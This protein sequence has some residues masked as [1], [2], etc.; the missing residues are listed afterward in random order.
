MNF[1]SEG[2]HKHIAYVAEGGNYYSKFKEVIV[3]EMIDT[4]LSKWGISFVYTC[5]LFIT[6]N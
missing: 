1:G 5:C 4:A 2:G 3:L 6:Q